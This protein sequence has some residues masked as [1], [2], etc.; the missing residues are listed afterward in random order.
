MK[1]DTMSGRPFFM[2]ETITQI[3]RLK[4]F[5]EKV[6]EFR[7]SSFAAAIFA[8]D[9]GLT[10]T[11]ALGKPATIERRGPTLESIRAWAPTIRLLISA[12]DQISFQRMG[13][14]YAELIA[15]RKCVENPSD[16]LLRVEQFLK[17]Q[18]CTISKMN[19]QP[20]QIDGQDP[21]VLSFLEQFI[22]GDI[23]HLDRQKRENYTNW[24]N[25][26]VIFPFALNEF[27][28]LGAQI[29]NF[30]LAL[31]EYNWRTIAHLEKLEL[32]ASISS[33]GKT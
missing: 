21:T 7:E 4:L 5:N 33:A 27:C 14:L 16:L 11:A 15:Q 23:L 26:S 18:L 22:Y 19:I 29:L 3:D 13:I 6:V 9:S 17:S 30:A 32:A 28:V 24:R 1:D 25:Q 2:S 12:K 20:L 8:P 10:L 31:S